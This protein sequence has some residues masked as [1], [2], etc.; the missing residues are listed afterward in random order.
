MDC[1]IFQCDINMLHDF[2]AHGSSHRVVTVREPL[3]GGGVGWH[4]LR[5]LRGLMVCRDP[6]NAC[7]VGWLYPTGEPPRQCWFRTWACG[8]RAASCTTLPLTNCPLT[9]GMLGMLFPYLKVWEPGSHVEHVS[10]RSALRDPLHTGVIRRSVRRARA[11][12]FVPGPNWSPA[13]ESL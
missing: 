4:R 12:L 8:I 5:R 7:P 9:S 1:V 13:S 6:D 10:P 11:A 3:H 2:P